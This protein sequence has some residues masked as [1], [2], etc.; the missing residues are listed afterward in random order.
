MGLLSFT[1]RARK[2][3]QQKSPSTT[4]T[5]SNNHPFTPTPHLPSQDDNNNLFP[6]PN[7]NNTSSRKYRIMDSPV[8]KQPEISLMDDIMNE[9]DSVKSIRNNNSIHSSTIAAKSSANNNTNNYK[10]GKKK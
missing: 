10:K 6:L 8:P 5:S 7:N 9:L 1:K 3:G 2:Q 4:I